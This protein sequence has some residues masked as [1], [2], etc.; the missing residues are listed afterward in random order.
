MRILAPLFALALL[1]LPATAQETWSAYENP[2]FNYTVDIPPGFE[3]QGA[4]ANGSGEAFLFDG[5]VGRLKV[6]AAP[7]GASGFET[8]SYGQLA[9][10][11]ASG[12]GVTERST[13]PTW[14]TWSGAKKDR[15]LKQHMI[16]L[17]DG[18]AYAALRFD[19]AQTDRS[20][21]DP[22]VDQLVASLKADC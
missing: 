20:K 5:R 18:K 4:E 11:M 7:L 1:A 8:E 9:S 21:F 10:D 3:G 13:T 16:A 22:L 2:A 15:V 14:A 19:Y 12:W 17:C 6:W